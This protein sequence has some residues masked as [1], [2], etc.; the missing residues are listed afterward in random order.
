MPK[1]LI[2]NLINKVVGAVNGAPDAWSAFLNFLN[3]S[4]DPNS[5]D[6]KPTV[7][8]KTKHSN[9][10]YISLVHFWDFKNF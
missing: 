5:N 7:F 8:S 3:F 1:Y 9:S 4:R 10:N 2:L 6:L